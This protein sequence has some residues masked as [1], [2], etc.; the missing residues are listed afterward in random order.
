MFHLLELL[1]TR[2]GDS[3]EKRRVL[4]A[5]DLMLDRCAERHNITFPQ[6]VRLPLGKK[7]YRSPHDVHGDCA[8]SVMLL[9]NGTFFHGD[10]HH[11]EVRCFEQH[12]GSVAILPWFLPL[13]IHDF[14]SEIELSKVLR[15]VAPGLQIFPLLYVSL[16]MFDVHIRWCAGH[17][18]MQDP[19]AAAFD[20]ERHLATLCKPGFI[21]KVEEMS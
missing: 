15:H 21:Y 11:P 4:K 16:F 18:R 1:L 8:I 10:Q 14:F 9:Q 17:R 6:D 7:A 13:R 2:P 12:P 20:F 3:K 5:L 19:A